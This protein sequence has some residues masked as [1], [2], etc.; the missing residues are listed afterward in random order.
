MV[1]KKFVKTTKEQPKKKKSVIERFS[2]SSEN[3]DVI[4]VSSPTLSPMRGA[5]WHNCFT[6][7]VY[8]ADYGLLYHKGL[9]LMFG[10]TW[11]VHV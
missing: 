1:H 7:S 8:R 3:S 5:V 6:V 11:S 2:F 10:H 4:K 9:I